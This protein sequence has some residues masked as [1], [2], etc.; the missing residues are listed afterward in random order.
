MTENTIKDGIYEISLQNKNKSKKAKPDVCVLS[1]TLVLRH[2]SITDIFAPLSQWW[3][4]GE[5]DMMHYMTLPV[6]GRPRI[7]QPSMVFT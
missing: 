1:A 3:K 7:S 4:L 2:V 5:P 6:E